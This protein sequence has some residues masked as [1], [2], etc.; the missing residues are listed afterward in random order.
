VRRDGE[1]AELRGR[2]GRLSRVDCA[3]Q[4]SAAQSP[5]ET[6]F[7]GIICLP[8]PGR[9]GSRPDK[10]RKTIHTTQQRA[11][12]GDGVRDRGTVCAPASRLGWAGLGLERGRRGQA[13]KQAMP[14]RLQ[15]VCGFVCSPWTD[16]LLLCSCTTDRPVALS[17]FMSP[18]SWPRWRWPPC[19]RP[20]TRAAA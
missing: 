2:E 8:L 11:V 17:H 7:I 14:D 19:C 6:A 12:G 18:S 16:W 10:E 4:R 15:S 5:Q 9:A 3:V 20:E 1:G 13:S